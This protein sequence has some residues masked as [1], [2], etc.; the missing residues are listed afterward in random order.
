M[1]NTLKVERA[2]KDMSQEQLAEAIQVS[3]QTIHFIESRKFVPS[4][5]LV[6]KLARFFET[7][8]EEI[9]ELEDGD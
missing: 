8:V 5:I 3:R 9:F 4:S 2:K 7:T 1:K 6:L